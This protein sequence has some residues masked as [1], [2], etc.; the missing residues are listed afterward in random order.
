VR[1]VIAGALALSTVAILWFLIGI[2]PILLHG[3]IEATE[4]PGEGLVFGFFFVSGLAFG[5][6][7]AVWVFIFAFACLSPSSP[8]G[9]T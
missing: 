6:F 3:P 4:G 9:T 5:V 2:L 8:K 1:V 7:A